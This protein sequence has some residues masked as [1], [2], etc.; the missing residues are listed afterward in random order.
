[1][2]RKT[3]PGFVLQ[4]PDFSLTL[5][6][7]RGSTDDLN[8]L[9]TGALGAAAF[10]EIDFL[11]FAQLFDGNSTQSG[12]ME[13]QL[14]MFPLDK[15]KTLVHDQL[16]DRTLRHVRHSSKKRKRKNVK[17]PNVAVEPPL[18]QTTTRPNA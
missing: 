8:I 10:V 12:M 17:W 13:E 6:E 5:K 2:R 16:F 1:M 7:G 9:G 15:P 18:P 4:G 14:A 11:A 3:A